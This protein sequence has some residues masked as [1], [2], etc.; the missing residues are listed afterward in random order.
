M[1]KRKIIAFVFVLLL[2]IGISYFIYT[3]FFNQNVPDFS[4][5]FP[6]FFESFFGGNDEGW[7]EISFCKTLEECK[8][9]FSGKGVS[10]NVINSL[11]IKCSNDVCEMKGEY[12]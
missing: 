8:S 1:R 3:T 9:Y 5:G 4:G 7:S 2:V 12:K 6:G 11:E 10:E